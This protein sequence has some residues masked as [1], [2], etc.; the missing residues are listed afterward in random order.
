MPRSF[1]S[2]SLQK[3]FPVR[4]LCRGLAFSLGMITSI[5][6]SK[7]F[8]DDG[9]Q[10]TSQI[11][12]SVIAS[13][14]GEAV[15]QTYNSA[16]VNLDL[17]DGQFGNADWNPSSDAGLAGIDLSFLTVTASSDASPR[18]ANELGQDRVARI[19]SCYDAARGRLF[20]AQNTATATEFSNADTLDL[21]LFE[22][23]ARQDM[24]AQFGDCTAAQ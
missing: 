7:S 3:Q 19:A 15:S 14:T 17:G 12:A 6:V 4:T 16:T 13:Q 1:K 21:T 8:A 9:T 18:L 10:L 5:A 22:H 11:A 23:Q 2:N 24:R 20:A